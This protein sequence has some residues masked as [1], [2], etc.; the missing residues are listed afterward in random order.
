MGAAAA[1]AELG[2][3]QESVGLALA[4][5]GALGSV[6]LALGAAGAGAAPR[7]GAL[8]LAVGALAGTLGEGAQASAALP[9][10]SAVKA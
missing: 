9:M 6:T 7:L 5:L 8:A 10:T 3:T 1:C 4:H 2:S